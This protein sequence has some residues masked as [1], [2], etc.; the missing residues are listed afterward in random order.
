MRCRSGFGR[1]GGATSASPTF[2]QVGIYQK[3]FAVSESSARSTMI[4]CF[5]PTSKL[6]HFVLNYGYLPKKR[7]GGRGVR[8]RGF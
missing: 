5:S 1:N 4:D 6:W 7:K 2:E 3:A 8:E